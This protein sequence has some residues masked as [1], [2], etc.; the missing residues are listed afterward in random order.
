MATDQVLENVVEEPIEAV[1]LSIPEDQI[2]RALAAL[3]T[4]DTSGE[5]A[6]FIGGAPTMRSS[7]SGSWCVVTGN[8]TDFKCGDSDRR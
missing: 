2:G 4:L 5:V 7:I 3:A 1:L 6:G 8:N